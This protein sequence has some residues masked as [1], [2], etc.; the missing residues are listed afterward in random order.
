MILSHMTHIPLIENFPM[1][2]HELLLCYLLVFTKTRLLNLFYLAPSIHMFR[3][4]PLVFLFLILSAF[5]KQI[6]IRVPNE[7]TGIR[8][9]L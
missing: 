9:H 2:L 6:G 3:R 5:L 4:K 1:T 7:S 8:E